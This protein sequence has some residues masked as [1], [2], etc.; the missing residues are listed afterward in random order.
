MS[1]FIPMHTHAHTHSQPTLSHAHSSTHTCTHSSYSCT[2]MH[3]P[4]HTQI[5]SHV[6][7][8]CSIFVPPP[9]LQD[10]RRAASQ[11]SQVCVWLSMSS[12]TLILL[13]S[14]RTHLPACAPGSF[15]HNGQPTPQRCACKRGWCGR[16]VKRRSVGATRRKHVRMMRSCARACT[17]NSTFARPQTHALTH[18]LHLFWLFVCA[19]C[20]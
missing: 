17:R 11:V 8:S 7:I 6:R 15:I 20:D 1:S 2:F 12:W 18:S 9:L 4:L 3:T 5:H 13:R 14:A 10:K 16:V 19:A